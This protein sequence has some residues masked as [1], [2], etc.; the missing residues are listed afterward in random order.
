MKIESLREFLETLQLVKVTNPVQDKNPSKTGAS[1]ARIAVLASPTA[2]ANFGSNP[3]VA[4][5]RLSAPQL[6]QVTEE[7]NEVEKRKLNLVI[8]GLR[9]TQDDSMVILRYAKER[10]GLNL[11][12]PA[13]VENARADSARPLKIT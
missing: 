2:S 13:L 11:Q 4:D 10:C 8:S 1:Y 9:E 12:A 6:R 7:V 3:V 5:T